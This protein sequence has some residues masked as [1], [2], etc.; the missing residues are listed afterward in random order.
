MSDSPLVDPRAPRT[1]APRTRCTAAAGCRCAA[2]ATRTRSISRLSGPARAAAPWPASWPST[3]FRSSGSMPA[4]SGARSKISPRTRDR[5]KSCSG[6]GERIIGGD[7]PVQLGSNNSGQ[8]VGGSTVHFQMVSLRVRPERFKARSKLGYAVDWPVEPEVMWHYYDR[9]RGRAEDLRP[10]QLSVGAAA[11]ALPVPAARDQRRRAGAGARLRG[12]RHRMGDDADRDVVGAARRR[13]SLRLSRLLQV[14]LLDQRQAERAGHLDPARDPRRRRDPR[15]GDGR[16][17]RDRARRTG[18]R[19]SL[20]PRGQM[21]AP[22]RE[23]CRRR[24]LCDRDAAA[25]AQF[26]LREISRT[27]SPTA[28][29]WSANIS[30]RNRTTRCTAPSRRKSAGTRGRRHWRSPSTG[31][32]PI[33]A[34][35][36]PAATSI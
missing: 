30:C 14:R 10:G 23:K 35:I 31:T 27:G 15:S 1:G 3:G 17:H 16:A 7:N 13:A 5:R 28:A 9:G 32:T 26:G 29:A 34:R 24:R 22:A 19:R 25:P 21:A 8:S 11:A 18:H 12:A 20:P 36:S 33:T 2:G 6:S 4:R